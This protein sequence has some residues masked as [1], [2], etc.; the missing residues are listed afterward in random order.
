[1][2]ARHLDVVLG[3]L[4]PRF[5]REYQNLTG[6]T[7][8]IFKMPMAN[9]TNW[10]C[11]C[12]HKNEVGKSTCSK[13][14]IGLSDIKRILNKKYLSET[15]E[16]VLEPQTEYDRDQYNTNNV[17]DFESKTNSFAVDNKKKGHCSYCGQK[18]KKGS[19][20]CP[21][22]GKSYET[23]Q[24][25][26][27]QS[28]LSSMRDFFSVKKVVI[29]VIALVLLVGVIIGGLKLISVFSTSTADNIEKQI[30]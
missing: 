14:G 16:V 11:I 25:D 24:E 18:V 27:S 4:F 7:L 22:C 6:V 2:E 15:P 29:G 13:C 20:F 12:G 30:I 26:V 1:M 8:E 19:R 17:V 9:K 10:W 21:R 23:L 5:K 28:F 3:E